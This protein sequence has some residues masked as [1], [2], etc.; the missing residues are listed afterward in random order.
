MGMGKEGDR[1]GGP[2]HG[3]VV[4]TALTA[5]DV[6]GLVPFGCPGTHAIKSRVAGFDVILVAQALGS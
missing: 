1:E 4:V 5:R 3:E 2:L 6:D